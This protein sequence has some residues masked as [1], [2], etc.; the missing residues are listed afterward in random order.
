MSEWLVIQMAAPLASFGEL[1]GTVRRGGSDRPGKGALLGLL[2]AALGVRRD[3]AEG[4]TALA[5]GYAVATR[6]WKSGRILQDFHTFQSVAFSKE[7]YYSRADALARGKRTTTTSITRR[8]YRCDVVV[9]AAYRAHG[10]A[11][12]SLEELSDALRRPVFT[13][14]LGRKACPLSAPLAPVIVRGEFAT[15][16]FEAADAAWRMDAAMGSERDAL[17]PTREHRRAEVWSRYVAEE[18]S[19]ATARQANEGRVERRYDQPVD[20]IAWHFERRAERVISL[21]RPDSKEKGNG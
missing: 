20:R 17:F 12:W 13:L 10:S 19:D 11:R 18:E 15:A 7:R 5:K 21:S 2:G 1:A 14:S 3:D 4:Q 8:E 9:D 16:A 6:V